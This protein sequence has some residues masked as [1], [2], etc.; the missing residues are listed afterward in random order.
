MAK[1]KRMFSKQ[2][3]MSDAFLNL[4]ATAQMLYIY[5]AID[6]DDDGFNDHAQ[7]IMRMIGAHQDD[8]EALLGRKFILLFDDGVI[9]IKHWRMHNYLRSD[10]YQET[11]YLEHKE[12]IYCDDVGN[13]HWKIAEETPQKGLVYQR[14]TSGIPDGVPNV[15]ECKVNKSNLK[16]DLTREAPG[17]EAPGQSFEAPSLET[18]EKYIKEKAL[19]VDAKVWYTYHHSN[20]WQHKGKCLNDWKYNLKIWHNNE[21]KNNAKQ[22]PKMDY[23]EEDV[24]SPE[25]ASRVEIEFAE[26]VRRLEGA[27]N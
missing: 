13:Y 16:K 26:L 19:N 6:A 7:R 20:G 10:R 25:E 5:L 8:L 22:I 11:P 24:L 18:V 27:K 4:P 12:Q 1:E 9:V 15:R 14:Y 17:R 21:I 3:I 2:I 23:K